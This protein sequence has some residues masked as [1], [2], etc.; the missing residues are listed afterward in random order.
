VPGNRNL[1]F[2]SLCCT[3]LTSPIVASKAASLLRK[4]PVPPLCA[5]HFPLDLRHAPPLHFPFGK[6]FLSSCAPGEM[7]VRLPDWSPRGFSFF[8]VRN[9]SRVPHLPP[10]VFPLTLLFNTQ[11]PTRSGGRFSL[12][13]D[14]PPPPHY[15][16]F[17]PPFKLF[18]SL[19]I[20]K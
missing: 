19:K 5:R 18:F 2:L 12:L 6:A 3:R 7:Y 20:K 10:S 13:P 9:L 11:K 15:T 16:L 8:R 4:C 14:G 17:S 1:S